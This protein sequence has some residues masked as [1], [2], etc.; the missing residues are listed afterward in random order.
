MKDHFIMAVFLNLTLFLDTEILCHVILHNI[1]VFIRCHTYLVL[2]NF[3]TLST[4][5]IKVYL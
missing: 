4:L 1:R 3:Y 2:N 5:L